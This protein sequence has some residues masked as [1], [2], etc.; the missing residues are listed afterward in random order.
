[1]GLQG[2][3]FHQATLKY[4]TDANDA[5]FETPPV[6]V[7]VV[8]IAGGFERGPDGKT[9]AVHTAFDALVTTQ[10]PARPGEI[11]HFYSRGLGPVDPVVPI[12]Y[13]GPANPPAQL[14]TPL[15]CTAEYMDPSYS[16]ISGPVDVLFAGLAPGL[17]GYYQVSLR[18][19]MIS[20]PADVSFLC[21]VG[22]GIWG[23]VPVSPQ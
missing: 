21:T 19:P 11:V 12:G 7:R 18:V 5:A 15:Q 2:D 6:R 10:N 13:P 4:E 23:T 20:Q 14:V 1:M 9:L 22:S 3:I 8:P 16:L 17:V